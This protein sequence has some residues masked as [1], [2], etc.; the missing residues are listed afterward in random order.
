MA[1]ALRGWGQPES[2]RVGNERNRR[3]VVGNVCGKLESNKHSL[4]S[5]I[6][7]HEWTH[8][9]EDALFLNKC[10]HFNTCWFHKKWTFMS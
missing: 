4:H 8:F 5:A 10:A 9:V 7:S 6:L 2:E 3:F 1:E